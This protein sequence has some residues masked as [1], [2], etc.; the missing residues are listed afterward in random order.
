MKR[1]LLWCA[2]WMAGLNLAAWTCHAEGQYAVL[3]SQHTY[4]SP[5]WREVAEALR[6]KHHATILTYSNQ[7]SS[8][9]PELRRLFPRYACLVATPREV[10][11]QFVAEVHRLMRRL[12]DDPYPDLFWGILTGYDATNALR[13]ARLR[14]PLTIRK[15][16]AGTAFATERVEEG[17]WYCELQPGRRV[18]KEPN[19]VA[20]EFEGP[21]DT[22]EALVRTLTDYQAD[23]FITSGHATE[24]EWQIGYRYQNGF[25]RCEHG[26]LYGID[27]AG[28]RLPIQSPNPKVY[29]PVGNCLM[30]HIDGP[31]AMALAFLNSGGVCQMIG[32]TVPTW[33]G[34]AGW[35]VLDYFLEQ[36]GR[37]TLTE[38]VFANHV[39]LIHRLAEFF[40]ELAAR[41]PEPGRVSRNPLAPGDKAAAAGLKAQD[42]AGLLH[43]RDVLAFYG[44][45]AWEARLA[46]QPCGFDQQL[47]VLEDLFT[48]EVTPR[49]GAH[50]F[51]LADRNGSQRGGRPV[52][53]F[54]PCRIGPAEVV[55]GAQLQPVIAGNFV[56]VPRPQVSDN[57]PLRVV[58][59]ARRLATQE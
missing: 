23:L 8:L 34:Y 50:S 38:A 40:P 19:G 15:V 32:Y 14:E 12:D 11:R 24:R 30:G 31:D 7:V 25:F 33:Y 58:F 16:A 55:E 17:V 3:I 27:T 18:R 35:G 37:Y 42:G 54:L 57:T 45:P 26:R 9:L 47:T 21:A 49:R 29:L 52:V 2:V 44:D 22:T 5:E 59:R 20:H 53:Q 39:A 41:E 4:G 43:D 1:W 28:R 6:T 36:P 13:I 10:S 46:P 48:F 56:L 51:D